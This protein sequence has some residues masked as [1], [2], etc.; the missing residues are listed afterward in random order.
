ML[1]A[2][3]IVVTFKVIGNELLN[4]DS[5]RDNYVQMFKAKAI[6]SEPV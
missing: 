4:Q 6:R 3:N 2:L 5:G 1:Q